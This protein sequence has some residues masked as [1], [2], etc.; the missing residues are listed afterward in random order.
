[1]KEEEDSDSLKTDS[2][3]SASLIESKRSRVDWK[4][5]GKSAVSFQSELKLPEIRQDK[6]VHRQ[7]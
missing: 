6:L 4:G 3:F 5:S 7:V 1:M 2:D